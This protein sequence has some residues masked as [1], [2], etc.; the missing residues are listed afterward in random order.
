MYKTIFDNVYKKYKKNGFVTETF[1]FDLIEQEGIPL[2]EIEYIMDQ[3]LSKGIIINDEND[4]MESEDEGEEEYDRSTIDYN[5]LY[6]DILKKEPELL[7]FIEYVKKIKAPQNREWQ[8]LLPK[9][10]SGND[11]A[12]KR[13]VEMYIRVVIRLA[14]GIS[15]KYDLPLEETIQD[16]LLGICVSI[17]KYEIGKN[18]AFSTYFPFWCRQVIMRNA[19]IRNNVAYFP[20]HIKDK[21]LDIYEM[22]KEHRINECCDGI[23]CKKLINQVSCKYECSIDSAKEMCSYLIPFESLDYITEHHENYLNDDN[24]CISSINEKL[25]FENL[26]SILKSVMKKC[27]KPREYNVLCMRYGID[28]DQEYTLEMIGEKMGLTRERIRQIE[29]KAMRKLRNSYNA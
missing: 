22:S 8:L 1:I 18:E 19:T 28:C 7:H 10:K 11:Y 29:A 2:F 25:E 12:K 6:N 26:W 15:E 21:L 20:V 16:G 24:L 17:D 4:F 9:A 23:N 3:L 13:I 27:L 14:F 5:E